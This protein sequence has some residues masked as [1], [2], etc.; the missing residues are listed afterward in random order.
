MRGSSL[1]A[2]KCSVPLPNVGTQVFPQLPALRKQSQA[3]RVRFLLTFSASPFKSSAPVLLPPA[4]SGT[5]LVKGFRLA[6]VC[7][8][9]N[10]VRRWR[11]KCLVEI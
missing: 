10:I 8:I 2:R 3:S 11:W 4:V 6:A 1:P 9:C 7:T 5:V